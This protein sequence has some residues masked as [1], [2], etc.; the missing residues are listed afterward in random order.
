VC[1]SEATR[2]RCDELERALGILEPIEARDLPARP[3]MRWHP[4][5]GDAV[6]VALYRLR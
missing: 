4:Y 5:D 2:A 6:H 3:S 1:A